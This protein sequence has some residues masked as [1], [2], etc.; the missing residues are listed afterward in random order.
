MPAGGP[1]QSQTR[2]R[3]NSPGSGPVLT[4][5][6]LSLEVLVLVHADRGLS[7]REPNIV[8]TIVAGR[9]GFTVY[10][11]NL[12]SVAMDQIM[13]DVID[14][15]LWDFLSGS[16]GISDASHDGCLALLFLPPLCPALF[17]RG[18]DMGDSG[19]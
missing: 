16:E 10:A 6:L 7:Q 5:S 13:L 12:V 3:G 8:A 17:L 18:T 14:S 15:R 2:R 4:Q 9:E 11:S 19:C 1:A